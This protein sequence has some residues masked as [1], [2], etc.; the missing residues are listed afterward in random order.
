MDDVERVPDRSTRSSPVIGVP[1]LGQLPDDFAVFRYP[2]VRV[3]GDRVFILY[4]REWFELAGDARVQ[5]RGRGQQRSGAG[6]RGRAP[7][8][9]A[10][11]L[12]PVDRKRLRQHPQRRITHGR[13]RRRLGDHRRPGATLSQS[14]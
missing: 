11:L 14:G 12:L 3:I 6:P 2:N 5:L 9:P 13:R 8:L 4:A 7:Q 1:D 10:L